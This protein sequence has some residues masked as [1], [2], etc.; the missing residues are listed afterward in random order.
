MGLLIAVVSME[1]AASAH[2]PTWAVVNSALIVFWW[3]SAALALGRLRVVVDDRGIRYAPWPRWRYRWS[4]VG[5]VSGFGIDA[6]EVLSRRGRSELIRLRGAPAEE[7]L[8][9]VRL[10]APPTVKVR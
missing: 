4:A 5:Q 9:V 3:V 6:F 1:D 2:H 7:V 8:D 10:C